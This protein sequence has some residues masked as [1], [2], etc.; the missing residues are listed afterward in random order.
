MGS[1]RVLNIFYW[2]Y[3]YFRLIG[4]DIS[5]MWYVISLREIELR[6]LSGSGQWLLHEKEKQWWISRGELVVTK[7][8]T[9]QKRQKTLAFEWIR[10]RIFLL[11]VTPSPMIFGNTKYWMRIEGKFCVNFLF[12][13]RVEKELLAS[14]L[15]KTGLTEEV[16]AS[17]WKRIW[18]LRPVAH[19]L[20]GIRGKFPGPVQ[21]RAGNEKWTY[22]G[23]V[24]IKILVSSKIILS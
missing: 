3:M 21:F 9:M 15:L 24:K 14:I 18:K 4:C 5:F 16:P 17:C 6:S 7:N 19:R 2:E 22:S 23:E 20:S 11:F 12:A 10:Y 1:I 13:C 8:F